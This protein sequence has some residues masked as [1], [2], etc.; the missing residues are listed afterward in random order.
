[1]KS[2]R[3]KNI[4]ENRTKR[5]NSLNLKDCENVKNTFSE[6]KLI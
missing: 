1:M 2:T 6:E 5:R 3:K 4:G